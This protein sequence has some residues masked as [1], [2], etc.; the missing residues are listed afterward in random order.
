MGYG[1]QVAHQKKARG[2]DE[3]GNKAVKG[4]LQKVLD[5]EGSFTNTAPNNEQ[6]K[7]K[8]WLHGLVKAQNINTI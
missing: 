3:R 8:F 2:G 6:H 4:V 7:Q 5:K 1:E